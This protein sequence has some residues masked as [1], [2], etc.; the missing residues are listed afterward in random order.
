MRSP[1][2]PTPAPLAIACSHLDRSSAHEDAHPRDEAWLLQTLADGERREVM[3]DCLVELVAL[4]IERVWHQHERNPTRPGAGGQGLIVLEPR[5]MLVVKRDLDR[6]S[7]PKQ[8][9]ALL[10][11]TLID[12]HGRSLAFYNH[13]SCENIIGSVEEAN[14]FRNIMRKRFPNAHTGWKTW[15]EHWFDLKLGKGAHLLLAKFMDEGHRAR[16]MAAQLDLQTL[17]ARSLPRRQRI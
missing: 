16:R 2:S 13:A 10:H 15:N 14:R 1:H 4:G 12:W 9:H 17:P 3:E 11:D 5:K 7:R 6:A 8:A